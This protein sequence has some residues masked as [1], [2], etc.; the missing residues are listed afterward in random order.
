MYLIGLALGAGLLLLVF[1]SRR[2]EGKLLRK[3]SV[4]LYK[5]GCIH[6][7]PMLNA[8]HVQRDLESLHPGQ[9]GLLLQGDYYIRKLQLLLLVLCAGT[10]LGV[11]AHAKADREGSLTGAGELLRPLPGQGERKVKLRAWLDGEKLGELTVTV[12]ERAMTRQE[13]RELYGEYWEAWKTQVLGDNPSWQEVSGPLRPAEELEG[14]PF[15]TSWWSSDYEVLGRSGE[16]H[17]AESAV[18]VTLTVVSRYQDF[19]REE[20]LE[21]LVTPGTAGGNG[22]RERG[23]GGAGTGGL[24]SCGGER[25]APGQNTVAR[26]TSGRQTGMAGSQ[27]GL[28]PVAAYDNRHYGS[29]GISVPGQ[30]FAPPGSAAAGTDEGELSGGTE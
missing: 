13:A 24:Q 14:Y 11:M 8:H 16:V 26:K 22:G 9:S 7:V 19:C 4:Y 12:P 29:C 20:E 21:L 23:A 30:G 28:Q 27:G 5:K 3:V 1:L 15:T 10:L 25:Q 6:K 18:L 17:A 2:E